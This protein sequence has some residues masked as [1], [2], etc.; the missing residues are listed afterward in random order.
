MIGIQMVVNQKR[1][2]LKKVE[3]QHFYIQQIHFQEKINGIQEIVLQNNFFLKQEYLHL[4]LKK[5]QYKE[6]HHQFGE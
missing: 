4:L 5:K 6:L 3:Q 1:K 2:D